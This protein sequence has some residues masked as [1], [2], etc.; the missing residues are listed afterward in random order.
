MPRSESGNSR[1][2]AA[3]PSPA[4]F[5][6]VAGCVLAGGRSSR[7][8]RDK[9][10]IRLPGPEG[11][12]TLLERTLALLDGLCG[13]VYVSVRQGSPACACAA[14]ARLVFDEGP[15]IGPL[16]GILSVL[17]RAARDGFEAVLFPACDLPFAG[18]ESLVLLLRQRELRAADTLVTALCRD[19]FSRPEPLC[20]VW[21]T[22]ALPLL[23]QARDKGRFSLFRALPEARWQT[24]A[25]APQ[26]GA[27][28]LFNMNTPADLALAVNRHQE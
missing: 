27:L 11:E 12:S 5:P 17:G 4:G 28:E 10:T 3:P 19:A 25:C 24:V 23:G 21:E 18:R 15:E 26:H 6:G 1:K 8:G 7:M 20:A 16:G 2:Q 22:A 14:E 13:A 9:A